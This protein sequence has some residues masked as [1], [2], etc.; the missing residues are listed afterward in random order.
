MDDFRIENGKIVER[1]TERDRV[2][3]LYQLGLLPG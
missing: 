2:S 1:W 3:R